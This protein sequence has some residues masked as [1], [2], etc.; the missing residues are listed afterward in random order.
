MASSRLVSSP[1][2]SKPPK[3]DLEESFKSDL[4]KKSGASKSKKSEEGDKEE[5]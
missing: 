2:N 4:S 5:V 3:L 1:A